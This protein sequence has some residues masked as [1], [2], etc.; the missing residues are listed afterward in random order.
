MAV[1]DPKTYKKIPREVEAIRI[2][3][4]YSMKKAITWVEEHGSTA[5]IEG[6]YSNKDA[7]LYVTTTLGEVEIPRQYYLIK[8]DLGGFY[9]YPA[10]IFEQE[11]ELVGVSHA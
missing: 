4:Y 9:S 2:V 3:D 6:A 1:D 8:G 10:E 11:Y 5:R 7:K